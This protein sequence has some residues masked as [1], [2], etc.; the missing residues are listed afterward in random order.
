[1][2]PLWY[3]FPADENTFGLSHLFMWGPSLLIIPK[4]N[5]SIDPD[6]DIYDK[7]TLNKKS[8]AVN[9]YLPP[10]D[11]KTAEPII[12]YN[13]FTHL[14]EAETSGER[15]LALK[16]KAIYVRGGSIIPIKLHYHKLS[17]LRAFL[18][19]IKLD[20]YLDQNQRAEGIFYFDDGTSFRYKTHN[21]K[22]LIKFAYT[23]QN[24]LIATSLLKERTTFL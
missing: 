17:L 23:E 19:P 13:Y 14:P 18:H 9:I 24:K 20:I 12:W 2:R 3:D 4:L 15:M 8:Y 10:F 11:S 1:M 6:F 7:A 22:V 5:T 21:E 16:E